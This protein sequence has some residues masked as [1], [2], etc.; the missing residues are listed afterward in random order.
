MMTRLL[1]VPSVY[2][3]GSFRSF[4]RHMGHCLLCSIRVIAFAQPSHS[5]CKTF[6]GVACEHRCLSVYCAFGIF[7]VV[8][9]FVCEGHGYLVPEVPGA[10]G[11]V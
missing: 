5:R 1:T 10:V 4:S 3:V 2:L 9:T 8:V 7:D 6:L 11:A